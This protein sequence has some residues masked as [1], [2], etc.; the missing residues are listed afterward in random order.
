MVVQIFI[1]SHTGQTYSVALDDTEFK[2][3]TG[4]D[5]KHKN[6]A[7]FRIPVS[8]QRLIFNDQELMDNVLLSDYGIENNASIHTWLILRGGGLP[9]GPGDPGLGDKDGK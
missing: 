4:L 2:G 1:I 7:L 9:G 3:T 6:E 8:Q 5:L